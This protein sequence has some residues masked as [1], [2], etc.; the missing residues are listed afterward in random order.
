MV[1]SASGIPT[2]QSADVSGIIERLEGATES[3]REIDG[4]IYAFEQGYT[5]TEGTTFILDINGSEHLQYRHP[6]KMHSNGPAA[7]YVS[8]YNVPEYTDSLD[9]ALALAERSLPGK[10][11][12]VERTEEG[13]GWAFVQTDRKHMTD[14]GTPALA[15]CI[16]VMKATQPTTNKE[17]Q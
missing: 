14:G 2:A 8:G 7:L 3:S 4:L 13:R 9:A 1:H 15:L 6:T 10:R 16:A 11:L 17:T 5:R 12:M